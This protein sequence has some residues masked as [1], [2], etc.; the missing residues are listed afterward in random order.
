MELEIAPLAQREAVAS[1]LR[2]DDFATA[3]TPSHTKMPEGIA[4]SIELSLPQP[5]I[6]YTL[7]RETHHRKGHPHHHQQ[8]CRDQQHVNIT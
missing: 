8:P 5:W 6:Q 7:Q 2:N 3:L 4:G 1:L